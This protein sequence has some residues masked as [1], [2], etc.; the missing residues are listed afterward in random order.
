MQVELYFRTRKIEGEDFDCDSLLA[1]VQKGCDKI[2][3][4]EKFADIDEALAFMRNYAVVRDVAAV[5]QH[6]DYLLKYGVTA[7]HLAAFRQIVKGMEEV[8][9]SSHKKSTFFH[10][11]KTAPFGAKELEKL[12]KHFVVPVRKLDNLP[13]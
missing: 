10:E 2:S 12:L 11:V 4:D 1:N 5:S 8:T 6:A 13:D 3:K 7:K 9:L